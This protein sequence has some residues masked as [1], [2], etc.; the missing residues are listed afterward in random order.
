MLHMGEGR[1]DCRVT[2]LV[3]VLPWKVILALLGMLACGLYFSVRYGSK[4][5]LVLTAVALLV[6]SIVLLVSYF[7]ERGRV[8]QDIPFLASLV[9]SGL[10]FMLVFPPG[11]VPDEIYHFNSSYKYSDVMLLQPVS[12]ESIAMREVDAD[13][14]DHV[15]LRD[16]EDPSAE[17]LLVNRDLYRTVV[18][19]F[20]PFA[21]DSGT[22]Q[23]S[24]DSSYGIE[25]NL[26]QLK[27][28]SALGITLARL[29]NL[30]SVPLF[31]M[32]RL[33]NL[34]YF[35]ALVAAAV[36]VTPLGKGVF[37]AVALL[38]MTLHLASSY[39]YDAG[40]IGLAFLFCALALRA[41][42]LE[43]RLG[44][45][46]LVSLAIVS[47][48]MAPC[49]VIYGLLLVL[50]AFIPTRC[51]P[52]RRWGILYKVGVAG[53]VVLAIC[54]LRVD[55][56][57]SMAAGPSSAPPD[58]SAGSTGSL[59]NYSLA[60]LASDPLGTLL[61]LATTTEAM[62]D[63]YMMSMVGTMLGWFQST[64]YAPDHIALV[65]YALLILASV[66]DS[67]DEAILPLRI[68]GVIMAT[69]LLFY[70]LLLLEFAVSW[71]PEGSLLIDG[72]QGRYFLPMLPMAM[73]ALRG[74]H[75][76]SPRRL[77]PAVQIAEVIV[78]SF[79][80]LRVFAVALTI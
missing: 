25:S 9:L 61:L 3:K 12:D 42:F 62:L 33:F 14:E 79:V 68:R 1:F 7:A 22:V 43:R 69:C 17:D 16:L 6:L 63:F 28:P 64:I 31:Y 15:L 67:D 80:L 74:G 11:T 10:L 53:G 51:F 49:K 55:T 37:K 72:V 57:I 26:P 56:F 29:L 48:L 58:A 59:S 60:A 27:L 5:T 13:F 40:T 46:E 41:I 77:M 47:L 19:E 39:S 20:E 4:Y 50:L 35:V 8:G 21:S 45:G 36:R 52:S 54:L 34:I 75:L 70:M 73:L 71:T 44:R 65:L 24:V 23:Y 66:P 30:G 2:T 78:S 18:R 32:G 38:P 76:V